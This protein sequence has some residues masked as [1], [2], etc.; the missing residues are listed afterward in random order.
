MYLWRR[1]FY[2]LWLQAFCG[3]HRFC[4]L[5]LLWIAGVEDAF[6]DTGVHALVNSILV[7]VLVVFV[8]GLDFSWSLVLARFVSGGLYISATYA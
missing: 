4:W 7:F 6:I 2:W 3:L 1:G 8:G 5:S